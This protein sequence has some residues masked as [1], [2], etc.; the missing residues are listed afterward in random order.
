[1]RSP[2]SG[3]GSLGRT[4]DRGWWGRYAP[5]DIPRQFKLSGGDHIRQLGIPKQQIDLLKGVPLFSAC[6]QAEL[7]TIAQL[8]TPVSIEKGKVLTTKG[9]V[10]Y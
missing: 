7:R 5:A 6:S 4:V 10:G 9:A 1:M 8:G 2:G 3:I